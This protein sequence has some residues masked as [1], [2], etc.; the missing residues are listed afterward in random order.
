[1]QLNFG[2]SDALFRQ[3]AN[4]APV[5]LFATADQ[6][7]MDLAQ[8]ESLILTSERHD[9]V[10]NALVMIAPADSKL[11]LGGLEGLRA[12]EVRRIALGNPAS[13]P[14]G[15]YAKRALDAAQLWN[16]LE[17]K[18]VLA[19]TV[20]QALDYVARGEV[21]AG[22][23]YATDAAIAKDKVRVLREV[24]LDVPLTY[25]IAPV[26][27]AQHLAE[28]RDFM[29]YVRSAAGQAILARYGFQAP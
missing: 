14:A 24:P 23:V 27:K 9:F 20:R 15:R 5:D 4:G 25:P 6:Q 1:M 11:A 19:Q 8:K 13:V 21:E 26:A 2:A 7:S 17:P 16:A 18:F 22:F 12:P 28:A 29:A 3:I 10:R